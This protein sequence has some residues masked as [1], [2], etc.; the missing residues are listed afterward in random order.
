MSQTSPNTPEGP[1][2]PKEIGVKAIDYA[3]E[4]LFRCAEGRGGVGVREL[5]REMSAPKST[6]HR[7]LASLERADLLVYDPRSQSYGVGEGAVRLGARFLRH[8]DV[9]TSALPHMTDLRDELDETVCLHVRVRDRRITL[10]QLESRQSLRYAVDLSRTYSLLSGSVGYCLLSLS[11]DAEV[12]RILADE[13]PEETVDGSKPDL[14]ELLGKV[15]EVR[16]RGYAVTRGT[17]APGG[18]GICAP[19]FDA[20]ARDACISVYAP[21]QR[22]APR[23]AKEVAERLLECTREVTAAVHDHL[24]VDIRDPRRAS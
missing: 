14:Q 4:I 23:A 18:V 16:R 9:V 20:P 3:A 13:R 2:A 8:S 7:I 19:I 6:I 5:A 21:S 1:D 15:T 22:I 10:C 12:E 11:D 24:R 17:Q